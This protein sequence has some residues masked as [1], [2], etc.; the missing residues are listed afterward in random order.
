MKMFVLKK[1]N[2]KVWESAK[3]KLL[4]I[5]IERNLNFDGHV[6]SLR[7]KIGRK[8]AVLTRLSKIIQ[9]KANPYENI[10]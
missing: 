7:K 3:Q 1:V 2:V 10:C 5:E 8:L 4:G 6:F 9:A